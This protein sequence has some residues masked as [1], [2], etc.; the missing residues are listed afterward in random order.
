MDTAPD[1][2]RIKDEARAAIN[3][4]GIAVAALP[5]EQRKAALTE[6]KNCIFK[7]F[8]HYLYADK[9]ISPYNYEEEQA[10]LFD[11]V[12]TSYYAV[13]KQLSQRLPSIVDKFDA[14]VAKGETPFFTYWYSCMFFAL[15]DEKVEQARDR[16]HHGMTQVFRDEEEALLRRI[17]RFL[18]EEGLT[19]PEA[20]DLQH[21][22]RQEHAR[23]P[24][25]TLAQVTAD[26]L[27]V[28]RA[29]REVYAADLNEA[30]QQELPSNSVVSEPFLQ[31]LRFLNELYRS[32]S[33]NQRRV[34]PHKFTSDY[35]HETAREQKQILSALP[36]RA[37]GC[38]ADISDKAFVEQHLEDL[39]LE[40]RRDYY[41]DGRF[42]CMVREPFD[43]TLTH[44]RLRPDYE[45][46]AHLGIPK[47]TAGRIA[48]GVYQLVAEKFPRK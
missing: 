21:F 35:I 12:S 11:A 37:G 32:F 38:P 42:R 15:Q 28:W 9:G 2:A 46:E 19:E 7:H 10:E 40:D 43:F 20:E 30:T 29:N 16:A 23:Q 27:K 13:C 26:T 31:V 39:S 41:A 47:G 3:A 14:T 18:E 44:R 25:R 17:L 48:K 36:L 1:F 22:I 34:V 24:Q 8:A 6:L 33:D 4:A 45:L 5:A